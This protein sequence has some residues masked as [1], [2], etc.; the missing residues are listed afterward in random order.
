LGAGC[1]IVIRAEA[2]RKTEI[3]SLKRLLFFPKK[4]F[5]APN[6]CDVAGDSFGATIIHTSHNLTLY[7]LLSHSM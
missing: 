4:N 1:L 5:R 3:N 7:Q 2:L 6:D